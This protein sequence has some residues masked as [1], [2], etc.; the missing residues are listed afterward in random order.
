MI[1]Y[2]G[3]T[4]IRTLGRLAPTTVFEFSTWVNGCNETPY[5]NGLNV[6]TDNRLNR[7]N[8]TPCQW[9]ANLGQGADA[10]PH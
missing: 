9:R 6:N 1:F 3:E 2:G 4:G 7:L 5:F 10:V 8:R